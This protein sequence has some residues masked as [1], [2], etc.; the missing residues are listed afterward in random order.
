[1]NSFKPNLMYTCLER[2]IEPYN[3]QRD[4]SPHYI[5]LPPEPLEGKHHFQQEAGLPSYKRRLLKVFYRRNEG[6]YKITATIGAEGNMYLSFVKFKMELNGQLFCSI[7]SISRSM[8]PIENLAG[9]LN[10]QVK[11][12]LQRKFGPA[13]GSSA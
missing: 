3:F 9:I 6:D 5:C 13:T 1:M 12:A 10:N 11:P 2:I 7:T 4:G 8:A